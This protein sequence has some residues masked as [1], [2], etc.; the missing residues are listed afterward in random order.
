MGIKIPR[1]RFFAHYRQ[2]IV[3][4]FFFFLFC[5]FGA[6]KI[7]EEVSIVCGHVFI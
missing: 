4:V 6:L 5:L 7:W 2:I 3:H 1:S